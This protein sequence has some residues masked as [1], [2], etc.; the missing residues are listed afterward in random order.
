MYMDNYAECVMGVRN[1]TLAQMKH[2]KC[3]Y[4]NTYM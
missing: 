3:T 4:S 1:E 2:Y